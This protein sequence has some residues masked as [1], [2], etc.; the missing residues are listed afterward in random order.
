M[1]TID[2]NNQVIK[3]TLLYI[4]EKEGKIRFYALMKTLYL[5]ERDHLAQWGGRI[6]DDVYSPLMYGP[7]PVKIHNALKSGQETFLSD[8]LMIKKPFVSALRKPNMEYLSKSV[9]YALDRA[10]QFVRTHS[11]EEIKNATHDQF[12]NKAR[13]EKREMTDQEMAL[14]G[15]ATSDML[16]YISEQLSMDRALV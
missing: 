9:V 12:Y 4:L 14:S 7:V 11:F 15:G 10:I 5:A 1:D 13:V 6:T 3:E 8:V 16:S 2:F